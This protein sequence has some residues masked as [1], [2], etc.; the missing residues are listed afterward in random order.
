MGRYRWILAWVFIGG[1][2]LAGAERLAAQR[3]LRGM[4]F[5]D[6]L[7]IR[8]VGDPAFSPDGRWLLYTVTTLNWKEREAR[9]R[10]LPR[11]DLW[12]TVAPR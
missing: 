4:T 9:S 11:L 12:R 10:S 6:V 8:A 7:E 5:M 3:P 2:S 1:I